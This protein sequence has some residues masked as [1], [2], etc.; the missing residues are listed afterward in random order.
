[1]RSQ[2]RKSQ[3]LVVISI[4]LGIEPVEVA[5]KSGGVANGN[6]LERFKSNFLGLSKIDG[7]RILKQIRVSSTEYEVK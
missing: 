3:I 4:R 5:G 6:R 2:E 1:M 7:A